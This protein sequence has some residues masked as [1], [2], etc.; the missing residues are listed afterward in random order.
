[1]GDVL[2]MASSQ[3]HKARDDGDAGPNTGGMGAYSPAP[4][5]DATMHDIIMER[6]IRPTVHG[7]AAEGIDYRG[8]LYAGLMI[9]SDGVPRVLEYDC[10]L[11]DPEPLPIMMRLQSDLVEL[12][13]AALE[14]RLGGVEARWDPRAS[15]G[16]VM[17]AEGYPFE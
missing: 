3:D 6:V 9:G 15:L 8:F 2:A 1:G 13:Q 10:R 5:V 7:L 14:G 11:G 17:A 4:V 16:V 12:C